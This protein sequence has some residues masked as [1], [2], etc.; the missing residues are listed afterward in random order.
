YVSIGHTPYVAVAMVAD[1]PDVG[2]D[3]ERIEPRSGDFAAL[4]FSPEEQRLLASLADDRDE[5]LTIGWAAKAAAA[6]ARGS[7]LAGRPR[8]LVVEAVVGA[9]LRVNGR[10][11]EIMR[12][13]GFVA[14]WTTRHGP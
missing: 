11:I 5:R 3:V 1:E 8:D 13:D 4:A 7:G 14:A 2:V 12:Q 6:Q 9:R 10:W